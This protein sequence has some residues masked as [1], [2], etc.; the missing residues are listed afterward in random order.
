MKIKLVEKEWKQNSGAIRLLQARF[1]RLYDYQVF[2]MA[3]ERVSA[4][5]IVEISGTPLGVQLNDLRL[6]TSVPKS[7]VPCLFVTFLNLLNITVASGAVSGV[8]GSRL[9]C[10]KYSSS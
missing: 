9:N 3:T 4:H 10:A 7:L 1:F 2:S 8:P 5:F 6:W